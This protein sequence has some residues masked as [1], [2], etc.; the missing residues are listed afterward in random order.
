MNIPTPHDTTFVPYVVGTDPEFDKCLPPI[1][2]QEGG[3]SN[4]AHDPGGMTDFGIIQRE[5]DAKRKQW[6]L[7]TQWD[8]NISADKNR[9]MY[10]TD[11]W[12]PVCPQ[13]YPGLDLQVF[14]MSVNG[15]P[16]RAIVLLQQT[17]DVTA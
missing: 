4:D 17:A 3:Y 7:P 1:L 8:K 14:N 9:P 10:Y 2:V 11:Y 16:H 13:L 5:Y 12:L 6:G 15:G